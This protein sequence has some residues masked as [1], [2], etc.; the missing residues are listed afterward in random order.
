VTTFPQV[1]NTP[2]SFL[3]NTAGPSIGFP[4]DTGSFGT[5]GFPS[6]N[7][8]QQ[9]ATSV[10]GNVPNF[11]TQPPQGTGI[12]PSQ[13]TFAT[14]YPPQT[15]TAFPPQPLPVMPGQPQTPQPSW[16]Q[17]GA[18]AYPGVAVGPTMPNV[19][20]TQ[21]LGVNTPRW[22]Q[23]SATTLPVQTYRPG[24]AGTPF[25]TQQTGIN[26]APVQPDRNGRPI[27]YRCNTQV[28]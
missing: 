3:Q 28:S 21:Q 10:F 17:Q 24:P 12:F 14:Q 1:V 18:T 13:S 4:Q 8:S 2:N 6:N 23:Q 7:I 19:S 25:P 9:P 5:P 15:G 20:P 16:P 22:L 11:V 27:N 26:T